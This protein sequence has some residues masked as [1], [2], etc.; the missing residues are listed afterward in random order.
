LRV[1]LEEAVTAA[2]NLMGEANTRTLEPVDIRV[3]KQFFRNIAGV[4]VE[5]PA[6]ALG[7]WTE[8]SVQPR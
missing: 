6:G 3:G 4:E 7:T 1:A 2:R 8:S 5:E